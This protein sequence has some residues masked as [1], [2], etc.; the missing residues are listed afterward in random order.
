[1]GDALAARGPVLVLLDNFEHL[2]ETAAAC[3]VSWLAAAPDAHF[4]VTSR[5]LLRVSPEIRFEL[6]PLSLPED[7]ADVERSEAAQLFVDR[8]RAS[9]PRFTVDAGNATTIATLVRRLEGIPLA[10]EL[11]A[12]RV[13]LF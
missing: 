6:G 8:V 11:A 3:L 4:L 5:E 7:D 12:S 9:D 1:L 13:E 2:V 10:I